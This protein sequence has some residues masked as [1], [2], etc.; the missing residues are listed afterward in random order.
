MFP[1][2]LRYAG[3]SA[4][5][6]RTAHGKLRYL[7]RVGGT[8]Q[9]VLGVGAHAKVVAVYWDPFGV[10]HECSDGGMPDYTHNWIQVP[11]IH[12]VSN[13]R[14]ID[15]R[16]ELFGQLPD[17]WLAHPDVIWIREDSM[18]PVDCH[19]DGGEAL[20]PNLMGKYRVWLYELGLPTD[21][22]IV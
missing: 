18:I 6:F 4:A 10:Y 11:I 21:I 8:P 2:R 15:G 5:Q 20:A 1:R 19:S 7:D 16:E 17:D 13:P 3:R 22:R 9:H 12:T 14:K